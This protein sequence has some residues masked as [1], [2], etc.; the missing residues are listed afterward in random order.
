MVHWIPS[1]QLSQ[2]MIDIKDLCLPFEPRIISNDR[3][4]TTNSTISIRINNWTMS[5]NFYLKETTYDQLELPYIPFI[6][7]VV[8]V[9]AKR[10]IT[11]LHIRKHISLYYIVASV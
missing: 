10:K 3:K 2:D 9:Y 1:L 7:P 11:A 8:S 6:C 5:S 4:E